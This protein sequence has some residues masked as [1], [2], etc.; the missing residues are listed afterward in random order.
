MGTGSPGVLYYDILLLLS[1]I[2]TGIYL[3]LWHKHFD[4]HITLLFVLIPV[5][6]LGYVLLA[7]STGLAEAL[8]ANRVIYLG[9]CFLQLIVLL[10]VCTLCDI[11]PGRVGRILKTLGFAV[12]AVVFFFVLNPMRSRDFYTHTGLALYN[13]LPYLQ[14]EYGWMHSVFQGLVLFYYALSIAIIVWCF[15]R[16]NQISRKILALL[17][18]PE[19]LAVVAF[20]IVRRRTGHVELLPAVYVL[21]QMTYLIIVARISLYDVTDTAVDSIVKNGDTGFIS[22]DYGYHYLGSNGTAKE[23]FP[24]LRELTV[25]LSV[26]RRKS[27]SD[28]VTPWLEAYQQDRSNNTASYEKDGKIYQVLISPLYNGRREKGYQLTITDNTRDQQY[29]RFIKS[30]NDRLDAEV[31]RQTKHIRDMHDR[32]ILSMATMVESR[33]NSTGGHIRRTSEGVKILLSEMSEKDNP[34]LTQ[35]FREKLIKAAP[36]H[37]MGKIAVRDV[38]LQK[39]GRFTPEEYEEMKAHAAEGARIVHSILKGTDDEKFHVIA[40]SVAQFH[41]E[42]WDGNGYPDGMKGEEI[43]L[44]ARIMAVAD[45]Y[46]ALVSKRVYKERMSFEKADRIMMEGMGTQFAP[47]MKEVYCRARPKLE[48]YYSSLEEAEPEEDDD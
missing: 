39:P 19:T 13:G 45:V 28:L 33:D 47:E 1:V 31:Q 15:F 25:D 26:K 14:K 16:K 7:H 29:I 22:I 12:G 40:E 4:A 42:R 2:L 11:R 20:F 17:F 38:V 6:C 3:F 43:P 23:V 27:F 10:A 8:V 44:E 37:D 34:E 9:G 30:Y 21:A 18:F 24:I 48:A 35:E 41:H 36:M 46:D 5:I 32:L